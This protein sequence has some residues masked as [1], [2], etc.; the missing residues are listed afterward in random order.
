MVGPLTDPTAHGGDA[1]D[2][3]HLVIPALPGFGFSDK[4]RS[5]GW[6][7]GKTASAWAQL[8]DR[9]GYGQRW[10]AQGGDWARQ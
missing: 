5:P 2:A 3:F 10:A 9:L 8:M 4:P 7:V 6:G 1:S